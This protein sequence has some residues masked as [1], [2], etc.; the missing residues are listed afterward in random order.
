MLSW[1][2]S[3]ILSTAT[4]KIYT[5]KKYSFLYFRYIFI[6]FLFLF[7]SKYFPIYR[8]HH[9]K[10]TQ[11]FLSKNEPNDDLYINVNHFYVAKK[12]GISGVARLK[13]GDDYLKYALESYLPIVDE[14]I[15][16][17]NNSTDNTINICR[18]FESR[19]PNKVKFYQYRPDVYWLWSNYRDAHTNPH[20]LA[21]YYNRSFS[22]ATYSH[23]LKV[24]DDN[25]ALQEEYEKLIKK[26]MKEKRHWLYATWWLNILKKNNDIGVYSIYPYPWKY[27]DHGIYEVTP[28]TYYI[29]NWNIESM[30][31]PYARRSHEFAFIHLK[32]CKKDF[33]FCN[34]QN[35]ELRIRL[36]NETQISAIKS[37][38]LYVNDKQEK[39]IQH[40][41]TDIF[42]NDTLIFPK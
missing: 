24:D 13:N 28:Y 37:I 23:V 31:N 27:W 34:I 25:I 42:H 9:K 20:W 19:Y 29:Q 7:S 30:T 2:L 8:M 4:T 17:D 5:T 32:S 12:I 35:D 6:E 15:L 14:L 39:K 22:K 33:W 26:I 38:W 16:I 10:I 40:I 41:L 21:Y 1:L 36:I 18:E 11:E 3:K